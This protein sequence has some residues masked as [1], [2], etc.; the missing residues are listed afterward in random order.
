MAY[1]KLQS[2]L[3]ESKQGV[4]VT[5]TN[6]NVNLVSALYFRHIKLSLI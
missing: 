4:D 2:V 1:M 3:S 6:L 5:R